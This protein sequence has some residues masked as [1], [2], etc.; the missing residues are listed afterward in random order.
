VWPR[1]DTLIAFVLPILYVGA[2]ESQPVRA[3]SART[4]GTISERPLIGDYILIV[5]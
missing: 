4:K 3:L 1:L 2:T 5:D